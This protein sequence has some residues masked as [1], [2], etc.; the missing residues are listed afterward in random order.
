MINSSSQPL[1]KTVEKLI[2]KRA[3]PDQGL[4]ERPVSRVE[5]GLT[6]VSLRQGSVE[7]PKDVDLA[8]VVYQSEQ[9]LLYNH[10]ISVLQQ[11]LKYTPISQGKI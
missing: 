1:N 7:R 6:G 3:M 4:I 8:D 5:G 11:H 9:H 10:L 2:L